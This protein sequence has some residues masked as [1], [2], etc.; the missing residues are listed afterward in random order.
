MVKLIFDGQ[1]RRYSLCCHHYWCCGMT[2]MVMLKLTIMTMAVIVILKLTI[3][4]TKLMVKIILTM[5]KVCGISIGEKQLAKLASSSTAA[6]TR[7]R[8]GGQVGV[9]LHQ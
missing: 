4:M 6:V 3:M 9:N 1:N 5:G 2:M 7:L 8:K